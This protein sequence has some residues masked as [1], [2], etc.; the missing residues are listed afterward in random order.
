MNGNRMGPCF[1]EHV[2]LA[3]EF[4]R[5]GRLSDEWLTDL[6]RGGLWVAFASHGRSPVLSPVEYFTPETQ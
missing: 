2:P 6:E 5:D 3:T 4:H 1:E